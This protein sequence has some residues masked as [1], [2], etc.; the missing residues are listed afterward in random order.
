MGQ[1]PT[2]PWNGQWVGQAPTIPWNGQWVGQASTIPW[3][4]SSLAKVKLK[5]VAFFRIEGQKDKALFRSVD[6]PYARLVQA[7]K[8]V[9][10]AANEESKKEAKTRLDEAQALVNEYE[11]KHSVAQTSKGKGKSQGRGRGR[12]KGKSMIADNEPEKMNEQLGLGT[13]PALKDLKVLEIEAK[14]VFQPDEAKKKR[15]ERKLSKQHEEELV[16]LPGALM[17]RFIDA[18]WREHPRKYMAYLSG[19]VHDNKQVW[20]MGIK[21]EGWLHTWWE[22]PEVSKGA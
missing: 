7:T 10:D 17:Q 4:G 9:K 8:D 18:A 15:I 5:P 3:N 11:E 21:A 2:I 1:A 16:T 19:S 6:G 20:G 22:C 12:G 13:D 14:S